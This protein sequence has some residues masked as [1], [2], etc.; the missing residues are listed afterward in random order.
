[1][2]AILSVASC[3]AQNKASPRSSSKIY[4]VPLG[5]ISSVSVAQLVGYFKHRL[6]LAIEIMPAV[7]L[8]DSVVDPD[9]RQ[10]VAQRLIDLMKSRYA[11]W[12]N[13]PAA[14]LIGITEGDMYIQGYP[15]RFA[16]SLREG[17]R[18]AVV[19]S[20]RMDPVRFG[21]TPDAQLLHTR[22]RKMLLKNI[23]LMYYRLPP[24]SNPK[25]VLYR[26]IL[27]LEELDFVGEDF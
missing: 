2:M 17:E 9:R 13:H 25:S 19:S 7:S 16:F 5:E 20:A 14:I 10:I 24:N 12:A 22:L 8:D 18:L 4:F 15:W 23:G 1:M 21:L 11:Q 6:G 27:G 26:S 3:A